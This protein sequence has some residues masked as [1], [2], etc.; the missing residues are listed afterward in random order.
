MKM[1]TLAQPRNVSPFIRASRWGLLLTGILYGHFHFKYLKRREVGIKAREDK[2][3]E[4]VAARVATER[5]HA[6][7]VEM[8]ALAKEAGVTAAAKPAHH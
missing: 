1:T 5:A 8:D 7:K 2:I 6:T 3:R 4:R